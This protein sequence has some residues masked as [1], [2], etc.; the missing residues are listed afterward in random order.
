MA[1]DKK[2]S[3][4]ARHDSQRPNQTQLSRE[5]SGLRAAQS[6]EL[7]GLRA[8]HTDALHKGARPIQ[9]GARPA[10]GQPQSSLGPISTKPGSGVPAKPDKSS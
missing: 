10:Q 6:D 9:E 5:L 1:D 7:G 2:Q 8:S 4:E 3:S